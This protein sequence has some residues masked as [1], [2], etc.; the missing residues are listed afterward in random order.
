[1][2]LGAFLV[3]ASAQILVAADTLQR[4]PELGAQ[5]GQSQRSHD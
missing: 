5:A 2:A 1:M 4:W 3:A